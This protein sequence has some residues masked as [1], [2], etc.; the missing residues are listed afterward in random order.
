MFDP[1]PFIT[2]ER[3]LVSCVHSSPKPKIR[4]LRAL[5]HFFFKAGAFE[6]SFSNIFELFKEKEN[7]IGLELT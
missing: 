2:P 5:Y 6:R 3:A 7:A 4:Y 1:T